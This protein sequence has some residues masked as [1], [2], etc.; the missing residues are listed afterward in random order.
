MAAMA[1][2]AM[3]KTRFMVVS[4]PKT[5]DV[6]EARGFGVVDEVGRREEV[7]VEVEVRRRV[8]VEFVFADGSVRLVFMGKKQYG[9]EVGRYIV[10][11][12]NL[13]IL[14]KSF[15]VGV[16]GASSL[17]QYLSWGQ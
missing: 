5:G 9:L 8:G 14:D 16:G 12:Q 15:A 3:P 2:A 7:D 4:A 11:R 13:W 10:M 6:E 17:V 1:K